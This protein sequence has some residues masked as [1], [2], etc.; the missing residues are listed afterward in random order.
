MRSKHQCLLSSMKLFTLQCPPGEGLHIQSAMRG[1]SREAVQ[2]T[3]FCPYTSPQ[4]TL[5]A[6]DVL[7]RCQQ[8]Q[9]CTIS[10]SSAIKTTV[11]DP[12]CI[13]QAAATNF[14][15]VNY[16][17][18]PGRVINKALSY[19]CLEFEGRLASPSVV[20]IVVAISL[21]VVNVYSVILCSPRN[22]SKCFFTQSSHI[23]CWFS[24][25]FQG[26]LL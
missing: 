15:Q 3:M 7:D 6:M 12:E 21:S 4:C 14:I 25:T 10:A 19:V 8:Q 13:G 20:C 5:S 24:I 26:M 23:M 18:E 2:G 1:Y 11:W 16:T 9:S 17:C 22:P